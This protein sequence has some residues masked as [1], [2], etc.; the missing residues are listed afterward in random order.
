MTRTRPSAAI[1]AALAAATLVCGSAGAVRA[2]VT[3]YA[4]LPDTTAERVVAFYNMETTTR[5]AGEARIG[6]GTSM[7]GG[8]AVLGG[9]LVVEGVVD[10]DVVVINGDLDVRQGGRIGG[11]ATVTGGDAR[12]AG[13]ARVEGGVLLYR[14]PLRYRYQADRIAYIPPQLEVGLAAGFDFPGGRTDLLVASHG[15]YNRIEGLPIAVGPRV[16]FGGSHPTMARATLILRTAA[17]SEID[18]RRLGFDVRAEQ[19][20]APSHGLTLGARLYSELAAIET[21]GVSDRESA[22]STFVLHRDFRDWYEREGWAV[23]ARLA[24]PGAPWTLRIEY[25]DEEH[26]SRAPAD[27]FTLL[28]ND[29]PWRFQP[30]IAEGTLR[31]V[32]A[33]ATWDTRNEP[34][35]PSTAGS[36]ASSSNAALAAAWPTRPWSRRYPRWRDRRPRGPA[37]SPPTS[38][39]GATR[40]SVR[41][42][43]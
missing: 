30:S 8:V 3:T 19:L 37:S 22:L 34:R 24:R 39:S 15:P 6:P 23:H 11:R 29:E 12:M 21:A 28:D 43:G 1:L 26:E 7:R 14:E 13:D 36:P 42:R 10:G 17:A 20:V 32:G 25:R 41:T 40:D 27:P 5:L 35:D 4:L 31:T 33:V 2:Q 18:P 38:T 16:R 9:T